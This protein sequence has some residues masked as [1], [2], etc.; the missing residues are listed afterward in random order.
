MNQSESIPCPSLSIEL[1]FQADLPSELP[2]D[3]TLEASVQGEYSGSDVYF[4]HQTP[5]KPWKAA[6][7]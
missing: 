6:L 5:R 3:I 4:G 7:N 1:I 2:S